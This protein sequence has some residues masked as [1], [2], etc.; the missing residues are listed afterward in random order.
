VRCSSATGTRPCC[1][2]K[3]WTWTRRRSGSV[4]CDGDV[5]YDTLV[6]AAGA[7]NFYFGHDE[8]RAYAPGLKSIEEALDMRRR[9]LLAFE[10]AEREDDPEARHAWLTFVVVG[11]GPTGVELA[12]ALAEIA[13]HTLRG[14]FRRLDPSQARIIHGRGCRPG[15]AAVRARAVRARE[16]RAEDSR[17]RRSYRAMVRGIDASGVT[18]AAQGH[19]EHIDRAHG[20]VGCGRCGPLRSRA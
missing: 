6:I 7:D 10:A 4:F 20:L 1:S 5:G 9:V 17:R 14:E 19:E 18:V 16:R 8:W 13:R 12:G 11:G 2:P 15:A 3:S